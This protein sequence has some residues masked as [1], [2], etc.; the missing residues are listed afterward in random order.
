MPGVP[1]SVSNPHLAA[2]A[3]GWDPSGP[4][5]RSS[6]KVGWRCSLG[7]RWQAVL[8]NRKR[9]AGCPYC[10]GRQALAGFNDLATTH[11]DVAAE[12]TGWDPSTVTPGSAHLGTWECVRGHCW[13]AAVYSRVTGSGCPVCSGRQVL[14]GDNDLTS[15]HPDVAAE[16][17]GWDPSTVR[18]KSHQKRAWR[19]PEGHSYE[20]SIAHRTGGRG[21]PY[22]SGNKVLAGFNDLV[23]TDPELATQAT[24]WDPTAFS[25][26]SGRR[27]GW[28]CPVG[29]SYTARIPD[30]LAGAGC[31]YCS[32]KRVLVGFNDLATTDPDLAAE[33][34]GWDPTTVTRG[35]NVKRAW[36]CALG[37]S[38]SASPNSRTRLG[39]GCPVCAGQRVLVGYNDLATTDPELAAE[40]V[41][42][43]PATVTR[44]STKRGRWV[45]GFGHE[46]TATVDHRSNGR[47]C[48]SCAKTGFDPAKPGW[49]YLLAQPDWGLLQVGIT[50]V[51]A[52]RLMKHRSRGWVDV[53]LRG[54]MDGNLAR[55]WE[56]DIL[57]MLVAHGA[58][59]G[60]TDAA[61]TFD[62]YTEAWLA[63]SYPVTSL[64]E[65]IDEVRRLEELGTPD[66]ASAAGGE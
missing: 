60:S 3:D 61:G 41:G 8:N 46:W 4:E 13:E 30:R 12:A 35:G 28:T 1:L 55:D 51:P 39:S 31:P 27:L 20:A 50:N 52:E 9:G 44:H 21:C 26:G 10:T 54:P 53:D 64:A 6:Q 2:E 32:N 11:P 38:W 14:A 40:A 24:G 29:H 62:G 19:C 37:H 18:G 63:T 25:R 49:L 66:S 57:A 65:L 15:T 48:P 17:D 42:W 45:C 47:G 56:S 33:A 22:C 34:V 59:V 5:P 23:T 43:D 36:R 7:H 58:V 16:A